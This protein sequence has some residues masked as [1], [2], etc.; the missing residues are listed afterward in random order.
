MKEPMNCAVQT[1]KFVVE[2]ESI[3]QGRPRFSARGGFVRAYDPKKS[4]EGKSA[5]RLVAQ[6]AIKTQGWAYPSPDMPISVGIIS[7]R[8]IGTGRQRWFWKA[9][10]M[11]LVVPLSKPDVD[12]V[13]KLILDAMTGVVYPDDKQVFCVTNSKTFSDNPRTEILVT[14]YFQDLGAIKSVANAQ[15]KIDKEREKR[16]KQ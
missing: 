3:G 1:L 13:E 12:N 15:I 16:K 2:G 9:A 6:E 4:S 10:S 14:G 11:G 8:K 5:V 7:Y